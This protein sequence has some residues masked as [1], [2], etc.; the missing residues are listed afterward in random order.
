M[1]SHFD[2]ITHRAHS[3]AYLTR[4]VTA[5]TGRGIDERGFFWAGGGGSPIDVLIGAREAALKSTVNATSGANTRKN[6]GE[7]PLIN[8]S[9][10]YL[11]NNCE[12]N[13]PPSWRRGK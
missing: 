4:H 2:D 6:T 11:N 1:E 9:A 12:K 13:R 5:G 7:A 10:H 8:I 3:S